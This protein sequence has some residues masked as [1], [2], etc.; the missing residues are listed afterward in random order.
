ML[1][2]F[3]SAGC[4][5][6]SRYAA[7]YVHHMKGLDPVM[8]KKLQ[9]VAFGRYIPGI[10]NSTCTDMFIESTYFRLGHEPNG[11]LGVV[12]HPDGALMNIVTGQIAHRGVS[13]DNAVSHGHW[14]MEN[15][16]GEWPDSFYYHLS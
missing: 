6:Y 1:P 15:F 9:Y 2:Y 7:F 4:H 11:A 16:K 8:T 5:N 12:T 13:A 14:A 3:R 10:Y